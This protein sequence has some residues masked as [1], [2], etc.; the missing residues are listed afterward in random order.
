M[1]IAVKAVVNDP[2]KSTREFTMQIG[3]DVILEIAMSA[4]HPRLFHLF[5]VTNMDRMGRGAEG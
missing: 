2:K 4:S 5:N 3:Q 1:I